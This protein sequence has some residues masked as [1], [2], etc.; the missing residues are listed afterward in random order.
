[1]PIFILATTD[2]Q[3]QNPQTLLLD[4]ALGINRTRNDFSV[5][6][7][8]NINTNVE[9]LAEHVTKVVYSK[10]VIQ[11]LAQNKRIYCHAT[12]TVPNTPL[13]GRSAELAFAVGFLVTTCQD[14]YGKN[15]RQLPI[16]ATGTLD[17]NGNIVG[18]LCLK[19]KIAAA[20]AL[21]QMQGGV[22]FFPQGNNN[23]KDLPDCTIAA[24]FRKKVQLIPVQNISEVAQHICDNEATPKCIHPNQLCPEPPP[25]KCIYPNPLC[26]HFSEWWKHYAIGISV[27]SVGILALYLNKLQ[28]QPVPPQPCLFKTIPVTV[29]QLFFTKNTDE[30]RKGTIHVVNNGTPSPDTKQEFSCT[31]GQIKAHY[32]FKA[33]RYAHS[34]NDYAS[35][36]I[37]F[38][39][40][41]DQLIDKPIEVAIS[42][43]PIP[44]YKDVPTAITKAEK[45]F[46]DITLSR[47]PKYLRIMPISVG[48][49]GL[50]VRE[51]KVSITTEQR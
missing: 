13:D 45:L 43:T 29:N 46:G 33:I 28:E 17:D 2:D 23:G 47:Q 4:V 25:P 10:V 6:I 39:D 18:I 31:S 30:S 16:A 42:G 26:P 8:N 50:E 7:R 5:S 19:E 35:V 15:I 1:M 3:C 9:V 14:L 48:D 20:L 34:S 51:F 44:D 11:K 22:I 32:E 24:A 49:Y 41:S 12:Y 27:V 38:Y 40:H 36:G 37:S 21:N